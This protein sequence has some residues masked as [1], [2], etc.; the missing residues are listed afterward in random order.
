[1]FN[2]RNLGGSV[3]SRP[4]KFVIPYDLDLHSS[5]LFFVQIVIVTFG[6]VLFQVAFF[7][8]HK[9]SRSLAIFLYERLMLVFCAIDFIKLMFLVDIVVRMP[10]L[11]YFLTVTRRAI[12]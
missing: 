3:D 7:Y 12:H 11:S 4:R 9:I 8:T 10:V 2:A 5:A 1:M 6:L